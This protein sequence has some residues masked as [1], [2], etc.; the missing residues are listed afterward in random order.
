MDSPST[1]D[2]Q[3]V[4]ADSMLKLTPEQI[5]EAGLENCEVGDTYTATIKFRMTGDGEF[6]PMEVMDA[7]ESG[8]PGSSD[9]PPDED[10]DD[11]K[12]KPGVKSP[13]DMG[14]EKEDGSMKLF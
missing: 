13:M 2:S 11:G 10:E 9:Q 14:M 4:G 5:K 6:E 1:E 7:K 12:A 3:E 8:E